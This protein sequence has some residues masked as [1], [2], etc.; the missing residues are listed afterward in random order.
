MILQDLR[1]LDLTWAAAGPTITS[2]LVNLGADVVKVETGS[3]PDVL[4]IANRSFGW[5][6]DPSTESSGAFNEMGAGKR[7][8]AIDLRTSEGRG[9]ARRLAAA[10]DVLVENMRPGKIEHLGLSYEELSAENPGLIMCSLSGS[11]HQD[12]EALPGYAPIFW[13]EGGAAWFCGW[14]DQVPNYMRS[15]IDLHAGAFAF[16]GIMAALYERQETGRGAYVDCS[17]IETIAWCLQDELVASAQGF[18]RTGRSGNDREP[19]AP[20]DLYP[21]RGDDEWIAIAVTDDGEWARLCDVLELDLLAGDPRFDRKPQRWSNRDVLWPEIADRTS[22][23]DAG[24]LAARLTDCSV[25]AARMARL[26]DLFADPGLRSDG[27]WATTEHPVI[28]SQDLV[29]LPFVIDGSPRHTGRPAPL[30]GAHTDSVLAGWVGLASSD[31]EALRAG[32]I[33]E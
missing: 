23:W 1:V 20:H 27:V 24:Q 16:L 21:C 10:A 31:I 33:L 13:A 14:P 3:R 6:D 22:G 28:G 32:N 2:F 19:F 25:P 29:G 9:I 12:G 26:V 30:L 18:E 5:I 4:R 8:V 11:G 17:A 15:P 7:S